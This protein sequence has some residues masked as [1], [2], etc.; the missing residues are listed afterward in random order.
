MQNKPNIQ[1]LFYSLRF[2]W[3]VFA[4]FLA[5]YVTQLIFNGSSVELIRISD[6]ELN[7]ATQYGVDVSKRVSL[8]NRSAFV[9]FGLF[10]LFL[11]ILFRLKL[12]FKWLNELRL[13]GV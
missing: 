8:F 7:Q 5:A 11:W 6:L 12:Q 10:L 4:L 13:N 3:V 9:G 1:H 2:E